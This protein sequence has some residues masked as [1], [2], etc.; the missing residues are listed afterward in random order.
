VDEIRKVNSINKLPVGVLVPTL[1]CAPLLPRHLESMAQ[2][3]DLV[4]EVVVVDSFSKDG[5]LEMIKSKLRH[6][7]LRILSHPPGLYQSWNLGVQQLTAKYCY[8][9]TVGDTISR[10]GLQHLT[11]AAENLECDV[12]MSKPVFLCMDGKKAA[13]P[14]W[15]VDDMIRSLQIESPQMLSRWE[16]LAFAAAHAGNGL[17]GS[18]A[19][20]L[21]RTAA[22]AAHP[23][24]VDF[25]RAGDGIWALQNC[26]RLDW[27]V[28]PKV[29]STFLLHPKAPSQPEE[30]CIIHALGADLVLREAIES[31]LQCGQLDRAT[32]RDLNIFALRKEMA[33]WLDCK[34]QFDR[35]RKH[36][37]PWIMNPRAWQTRMRR[38]QH[39]R[40]LDRLK[41]L[42]LAKL[43]RQKLHHKEVP[44]EVEALLPLSRQS[45]APE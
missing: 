22:L 34:R 33:E 1:S 38:N 6:P 14:F 23:F 35:A 37:F 7:R 20:N 11:D 4:E 16:F 36:W 8:I 40:N 24:S 45:L 28:T 9:S 29:C 13:A 42:V 27:G 31:E 30:D 19:S 5:T 3:L 26:C 41:E 25:G 43:Y 32:L 2:W 18:S 12:M 10:D 21:T 44:H 39:A 15:P 17:L